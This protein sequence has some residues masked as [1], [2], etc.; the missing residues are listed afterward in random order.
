[1]YLFAYR[2]NDRAL[3]LPAV[4]DMLEH[5]SLKHTNIYVHTLDLVKRGGESF[6]TQY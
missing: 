1:M 5:S 4:K 3:P 2:A 6:I